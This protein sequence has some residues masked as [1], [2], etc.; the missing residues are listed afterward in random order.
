MI[1][2]K[3]HKFEI[4]KDPVTSKGKAS[5]GGRL[6]LHKAGHGFMT[7]SSTDSGM[8]ASYTDELEVVF[9]NG[10][11]MREQTFDDVRKTSETY[12]EYEINK[13]KVYA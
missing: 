5:K 7:M 4:K 2:G 3:L 10:E 6:K 8:W 1:D 13:P 9:E 11:I 12:L